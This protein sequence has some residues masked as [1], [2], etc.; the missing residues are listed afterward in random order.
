MSCLGKRLL[1]RPTCRLQNNIIMDHK[2]T[3]WK[4]W[5]GF[6]WLRTENAG[7]VF[8]NIAINHQAAKT[9][10]EFLHQLIN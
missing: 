4:V 7:A 6:I 1:G 10:G 3:A 2:E 5:N 8:V 9:V